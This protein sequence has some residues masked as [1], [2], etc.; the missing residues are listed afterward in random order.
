MIMISL[1][2]VL[3]LTVLPALLTQQLICHQLLNLSAGGCSS[4][5]AA[6]D[7][8][9]VP[10]QKHWRSNVGDAAYKDRPQTSGQ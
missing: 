2:S 10:S 7:Q 8:R 9:D 3:P 5:L 6:V 1:D 4:L